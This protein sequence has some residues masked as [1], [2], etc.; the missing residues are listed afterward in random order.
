MAWEELGQ[1]RAKRFVRTKVDP[2]NGQRAEYGEPKAA[3]EAADRRYGG[4]QP[5]HQ[6]H[7]SNALAQQ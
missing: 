3:V 7:L 5:L 6:R 1:A 2:I 4:P